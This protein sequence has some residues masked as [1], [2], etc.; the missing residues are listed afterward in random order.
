MF[1]LSEFRRVSRFRPSWIGQINGNK[2]GDP[3]GAGAEDSD[4]VGKI[5]R[6]ADAVRD[7]HHGRSGLGANIQQKVLHLHPRQFVERAEWLVHQQQFWLMNK[8]AAQGDALLHAA[9]ELRRVGV[10]E[11]RQ[12]DE[13]Q[14]FGCAL[15][16]PAVG[17]ALNLNREEHVFK[18]CAPGHQI[19]LLKDHSEIR[20]RP[21]DPSAI[22]LDNA[23]CL[24][25]KPRSNTK[26]SSF[27]AA[28]G[29]QQANQLPAVKVERDIVDGDKRRLAGTF[30]RFVD[31]FEVTESAPRI[32]R[33]N[34][35]VFRLRKASRT[36]ESITA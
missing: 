27:S 25:D 15:S 24:R 4:F 30:K 18:H 9:G 20:L 23:A 17:I 34:R 10:F 29:P 5:N 36:A 32:R 8:R 35:S 6:L 19:R 14:E 21:F 16:G 28:A 3:G 12:A 13:R 7:Q 22:D 31:V 33:R 26:K 2:I 11:A 1:K